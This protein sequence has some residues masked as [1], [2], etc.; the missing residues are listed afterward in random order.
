MVANLIM[1]LESQS[2][3]KL[4]VS[5]LNGGSIPVPIFVH[6]MALAHYEAKPTK[7]NKPE[8]LELLEPLKAKA[9]WKTRQTQFNPG[10]RAVLEVTYGPEEEASPLCLHL[11]FRD[12]STEQLGGGW[13]RERVY[14][15]D[16]LLKSSN[17]SWEFYDGATKVNV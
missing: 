5:L 13:S 10:A 4:R 1:A 6:A 11:Q 9:A 17:H 15:Y 14:I 12:G 8:T 16:L 3:G 7:R 2:P